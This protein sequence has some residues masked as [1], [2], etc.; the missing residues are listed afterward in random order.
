MK[1]MAFAVAAMAAVSGTAAAAD[2]SYTYIEGG[3]GASRIDSSI[4]QQ[5]TAHQ[6]LHFGDLHPEGYYGRA[7][8]ELG[9]TVYLFGGYRRGDDQARFDLR[10]GAKPVTGSIDSRVSESHLGLGFHTPLS[11]R[12]DLIPEVAYLWTGVKATTASAEANRVAIAQDYSGLG[13][14]RVSL[15]VRSRMTNHFD[16]WAKLNYTDGDAYDSELGATLGGHARFNDTWGVVG[17]ITLGHTRQQLNLCIR[18]SF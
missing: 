4:D 9:G 3:Y 16:G 11:D 17:E 1:K 8:V 7:S 6:W 10:G 15:G 14:V 18:A 12:T 2:L 5:T 13:D